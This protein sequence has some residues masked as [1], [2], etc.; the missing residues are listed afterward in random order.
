MADLAS[1]LERLAQLRNDGMLTEEQFE[2]AKAKILGTA[3][4]EPQR[5]SRA[6]S[7]DEFRSAIRQRFDA[8]TP[9]PAPPGAPTGLDSD[10]PGSGVPTCPSCGW[11]DSVQRL[12]AA[13]G[14]ETEYGE[15]SEV[16]AGSTSAEPDWCPWDFKRV[17]PRRV[18]LGFAPRSAMSGPS[19]LSPVPAPAL[20]GASAPSAVK[21]TVGGAAAAVA[22][23]F[24]ASPAAPWAYKR[25]KKRLAAVDEAPTALIDNP[26][27]V[28]WQYAA[29]KWDQLLYCH[30]C[31][32]VFLPHGYSPLI[33]TP[34][35]RDY[36]HGLFAE[37]QVTAARPAGTTNQASDHWE[38][39]D[40]KVPLDIMHCGTILTKA[41]DG[42][43]ERAE[44]I[45]RDHVLRAAA[46]GWQA[47]GTTDFL[48]LCQH[49]LVQHDTDPSGS[50]TFRS[51]TI[52]AKR[53][54][55]DAEPKELASR[56]R[57]DRQAPLYGAGTS[58]SPYVYASP[59]IWRCPVCRATN[60]KTSSDCAA[61]GT[62]REPG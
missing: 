45:I 7:E 44:T 50:I 23:S 18:I 47:E 3:V 6:L 10:Q 32:G 24:I 22:V 53:F 29:Q 56:L 55:Y 28:H 17:V 2:A 60:H 49:D 21:A 52:R 11:A 40:L 59:S 5:N 43:A 14:I 8:G 26:L 13:L 39:T 31:D 4:P 54:T 48:Y 62:P 58:D 34:Q 37:M 46:D 25:V 33:P 15:S 41:Q 1:D 35:A 16:L 61:C 42:A 27:W 20:S 36:F 51:A 30:R 19:A 12:S 38:Y 57:G 9:P